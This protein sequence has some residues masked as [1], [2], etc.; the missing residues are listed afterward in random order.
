MQEQYPDNKFTKALYALQNNLPVRLIDPKEEKKKKAEQ[1]LDMYLE[2]I[3]TAPDSA[4]AG[5]QELTNSPYHKIKLAAN[6]RLGWY[7]SFEQI[8]T[9]LAKPYLKAVLDEPEAGEYAVVARRFFDGNKFLLR[10]LFPVVIPQTDTTAVDSTGADIEESIKEWFFPAPA[11]IYE[12]LPD[13]LKIYSGIPVLMDSLVKAVSPPEDTT[14]EKNI[15]P[16]M[17]TPDD[18][19]PPPEENPVPALP[20]EPIP[21]KK[22]E[23]PLE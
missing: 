2:Q 8:D 9:L 17:E 15:S 10:G 14:E 1:L 11:E 19:I 3:Y 21:E 13:S 6:Y 16:E 7:Y 18:N 12:T 20:E 5:L 22:E 23:L 4:L